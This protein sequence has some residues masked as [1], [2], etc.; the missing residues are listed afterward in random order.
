MRKPRRFPEV[1]IDMD[2]L[3]KRTDI[4]EEV[5]H[6]DRESIRVKMNHP[7]FGEG[8]TEIYDIDEN[9]NTLALKS[10]Y[11]PEMQSE[12]ELDIMSDYYNNFLLE[13]DETYIL[14]H[15]PEVGYYLLSRNVGVYSTNEPWPN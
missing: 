5:A 9:D 7:V 10:I 2:F 1:F 3:E 15:H 13:G 4:I 6:I 8:T 14:Y 12:E 11:S